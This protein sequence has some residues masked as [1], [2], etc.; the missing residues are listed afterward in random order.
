VRKN[1]FKCTHDVTPVF[2]HTTSMLLVVCRD[3]KGVIF[4]QKHVYVSQSSF[5]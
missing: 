2:L 1:I 3:C 4:H 5:R